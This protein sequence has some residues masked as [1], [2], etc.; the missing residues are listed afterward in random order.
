MLRR[1]GGDEIHCP[2]AAASYV[3]GGEEL[4]H[5]SLTGGVIVTDGGGVGLQVL[6]LGSLFLRPHKGVGSVRVEAGGIDGASVAVG[7][8]RELCC[9]AAYSFRLL[10]A[11]IPRLLPLVQ[12]L[13]MLLGLEVL[14]LLLLLQ[15]LLQGLPLQVLL[16]VVLLQVVL[17]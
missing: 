12:P 11:G 3:S 10:R 6:R 17:L 5:L 1:W 16:Q 8:L 7:L 4:P 14:L 15:V 2:R 9:I 13:A